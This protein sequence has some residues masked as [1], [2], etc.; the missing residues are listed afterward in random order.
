MQHSSH[1]F[2]HFNQVI[3]RA[4]LPKRFNYPFKYRVHSLCELAANEVFG[5]LKQLPDCMDLLGLSSDKGQGRL[6]GVL[7]VENDQ[8][9]IGYLMAYE[10][11]LVDAFEQ[12]EFVS[13][14]FDHE[15][16]PNALLKLQQ[17]MDAVQAEI[18]VLQQS[19]AEQGLQKQLAAYLTQAENELNAFKQQRIESRKDRKLRRMRANKIADKVARD[20]LLAELAQESIDQNKALQALEQ[21]WQPHIQKAQEKLSEVESEINDLEADLATLKHEYDVQFFEQYQLFNSLGETRRLNSL[22][23]D[24]PVA[25]TGDCVLPKLL[26]HAFKNQLTPL[27]FAEFWLGKQPDEQVRHHLNFYP[28]NRSR[29]ELVLSHMLKDVEIDENQITQVLK[30]NKKT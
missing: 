9:E 17:R 4:T 27:N 21:H 26:Q 11:R 20:A 19:I 5:S 13:P 3:D 22:F 2:H 29:C 1:F 24:V 16:L 14:I 6:F 7:L 18:A 8:N 28:V 23:E 12:L 15:N 25:G 30:L 10:G